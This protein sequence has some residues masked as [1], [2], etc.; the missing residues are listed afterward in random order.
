MLFWENKTFKKLLDIFFW[1]R[2]SP[3][4]QSSPPASNS[5]CAWQ[6]LGPVVVSHL[7]DKEYAEGNTFEWFEWPVI[8]WALRCVKGLVSCKWIGGWTNCWW[9]TDTSVKQ[10]ESKTAVPSAASDVQLDDQSLA[11]PVAHMG[12]MLMLTVQKQ[13]R[14][15][16][17]L[18]IQVRKLWKN[19]VQK[20]QRGS[21]VAEWK[22]SM[23]QGWTLC[24]LLITNVSRWMTIQLTYRRCNG[25]QWWLGWGRWSGLAKHPWWTL[26]WRSKWLACARATWQ[27]DSWFLRSS[28]NPAPLQHAGLGFWGWVSTGHHRQFDNKNGKHNEPSNRGTHVGR[29][30]IIMML[31]WA[32]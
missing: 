20:K 15:R 4:P 12:N 29:S 23:R 19:N 32:A 13:P 18:I 14:H 6:P 27:M 5:R 9:I 16:V 8:P 26:F 11:M 31:W 17:Q 22:W 1:T 10:V 2:N 25:G 24:R 30:M 3:D 21:A 28:W 7:P